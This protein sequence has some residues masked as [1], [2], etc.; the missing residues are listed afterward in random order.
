MP[1]PVLHCIALAVVSEWY[2]FQ[3]RTG[4]TLLSTSISFQSTSGRLSS[5]TSRFRI[6]HPRAYALCSKS[7]GRWMPR[8][9]AGRPGDL[10]AMCS[11][12]WRA[13]FPTP[14]TCSEVGRSPGSRRRGR[15]ATLPAGRSARAGRTSS[16]TPPGSLPSRPWWGGS[17]LEPGMA[18]PVGRHGN[19][20]RDRFQFRYRTAHSGIL[21]RC[22]QVPIPIAASRLVGAHHETLPRTMVPLTIHDAFSSVVPRMLHLCHLIVAHRTITSQRSRCGLRHDAQ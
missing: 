13:S 10:T 4:T 14:P 19:P 6:S 18:S 9:R 5:S 3:P 15:T 11:E 16:R 21:P 2:Q 7:I 20:R 8:R 1:C 22:V 17:S 12:M